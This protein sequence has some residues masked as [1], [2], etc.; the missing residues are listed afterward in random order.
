MAFMHFQASVRREKGVAARTTERAVKLGKIAAERVVLPITNRAADLG[1]VA[2]E[3][4]PRRTPAERLAG[5]I[6]ALGE[7]D[8]DRSAFFCN[9]GYMRA[10]LDKL[11]SSKSL[12]E[13]TLTIHTDQEFA[14]R[15]AGS[16][17]TS[18][19]GL[20]LPKGTTALSHPALSYLMSESYAQR[21]AS[22]E[23]GGSESQD[24]P[25][26]R[27]VEGPDGP[28]MQVRV[29]EIPGAILKFKSSSIAA[30]MGRED[31]MPLHIVARIEGL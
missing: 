21:V 14:E 4:I 25:S 7:K 1:K 30:G 19:C 17:L 31:T 16:M 12:R 22:Q 24:V 9:G 23:K 10:E 20:E 8:P 18:L 5:S 2:V 26:V 28:F 6:V 11:L 29:P 3:S 13:V 15:L 27:Y